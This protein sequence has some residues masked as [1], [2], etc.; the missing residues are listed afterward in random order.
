MRFGMIPKLMI[1]VCLALLFVLLVLYVIISTRRID[2]SDSDP[3]K[4]WLRKDE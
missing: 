3:R 2:K 1:I 4:M